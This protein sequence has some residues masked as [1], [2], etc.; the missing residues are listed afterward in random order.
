MSSPLG[1]LLGDEGKIRRRVIKLAIILLC[2]GTTYYQVL[3]NVNFDLSRFFRAT[4][5]T[6][7]SNL[8]SCLVWSCSIERNCEFLFAPS[9][10]FKPKNL[11]HLNLQSIEGLSQL[12]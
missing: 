1:V 11:N 8:K 9:L 6:V 12:I 2:A 4:T 10:G 5:A 7:P 3:L